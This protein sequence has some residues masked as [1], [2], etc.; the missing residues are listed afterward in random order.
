MTDCREQKWRNAGETVIC[1][2]KEPTTGRGTKKEEVRGG[3]FVVIEKW[4]NI[5]VRAGG[6][7][8]L[9]RVVFQLTVGRDAYLIYCTASWCTLRIWCN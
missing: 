7:F 9:E 6:I 5:V 2:P 4:E 3:L 8:I 1:N